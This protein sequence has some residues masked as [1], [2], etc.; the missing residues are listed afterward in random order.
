VT[1]ASRLQDTGLRSAYLEEAAVLRT[2]LS[3]ASIISACRW[4]SCREDDLA[5][6][7]VCILPDGHQDH[8]N[9]D[10]HHGVAQTRP[11]STGINHDL[12]AEDIAEIR[13][14]LGT[15]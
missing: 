6:V 7:E 4:L 2:N 11:S 8:L 1:R 15:H 5:N 12:D 10:D 3:T 9:L 13:R 14:L